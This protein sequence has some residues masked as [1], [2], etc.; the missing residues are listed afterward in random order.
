MAEAL[1]IEAL[2]TVML[3]S[4]DPSAEVREATAN[5]FKIIPDAIAAQR[6]CELLDDD[7]EEVRSAAILGLI[8][9]QHLAA[10]QQLIRLV[11]DDPSSTVRLHAA[12]ALEAFGDVQRSPRSCD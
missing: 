9:H 10:G 6:L 12:R 8:Q 2:P 1:G 5:G 11:E 7:S 4:D 3:L